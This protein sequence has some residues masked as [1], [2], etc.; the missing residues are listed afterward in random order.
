MEYLEGGR[1]IAPAEKTIDVALP[2]ATLE[3]M[4]Q[5]REAVVPARLHD[6]DGTS[7]R[8]VHPRHQ[9]PTTIFVTF[10][11]S[12]RCWTSEWPRRGHSH[13]T[14]AGTF[15]ASSA[16]PRPSRSSVAS[17]QTVGRVAAG[18][19]LWRDL[20]Y[21]RLLKNAPRPRSS[22]VASR[23]QNQV[24]MLQR[25]ADVPAERMDICA[26]AASKNPKI[27]NHPTPTTCRRDSR[28][29]IQHFAGVPSDKLRDLLRQ[30]SRA[31]VKKCAR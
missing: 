3:I 13:V 6:L 24:L 1:R 28:V 19:L 29:P 26:K 18:V 10:E 11:G 5:M 30:T 21:R 31:S 7:L 25:A 4:C 17:D 23:A 22:R 2:L 15:R 12:V 9:A 8:L 27:A 20:T 16:M 14:E